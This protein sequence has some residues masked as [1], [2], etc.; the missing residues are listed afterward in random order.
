LTECRSADWGIDPVLGKATFNIGVFNGGERPNI[1]PA[2]ATASI[3]IRTIES[4]LASEERMRRIVGSRARLEITGGADPQV[5]HVVDG[6]PTTV[7]SFGSDVPY[8]GSLGKRLL[9]GPGS[10]LDAHTVEE[11]IGKADM[12]QG[13]DLYERLVR[14]LLA[15]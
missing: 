14:K 13:V 6:F 15:G 4:R 7:V 10:I 11:K 12:I 5:M 8:L 1:V 3:M 9:A 2:H